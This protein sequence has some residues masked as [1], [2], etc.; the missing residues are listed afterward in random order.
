M[1]LSILHGVQEDLGEGVPGGRGHKADSGV[2]GVSV[3]TVHTLHHGPIPTDIGVR[4]IQVYSRYTTC[5]LAVLG[6]LG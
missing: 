5:I 6:T 2:H 3:H 1:T 4:D